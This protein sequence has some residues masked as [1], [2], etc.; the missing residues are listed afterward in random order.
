MKACRRLIER[1]RAQLVATGLAL[2]LP[3]E[4]AIAAA[5]EALV[6]CLSSVENLEDGGDLGPEL[7]RQLRAFAEHV[8]SRAPQ[9]RALE[10]LTRDGLL[11]WEH[12]KGIVLRCELAVAMEALLD[13][14][15]ASSR[16]TVALRVYAGLEYAE[17]AALQE[18][19]EAEVT[20]FLSTA[21]DTIRAALES[22]R[23][24]SA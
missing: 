18:I 16:Q 21:M 11:R 8:S 13:A 24:A 20:A 6:T 17:I 4:Q 12:G 10:Q 22:T 19:S 3:A 15:P 9:A 14:L 5:E 2:C 23:E 7:L 1:Y